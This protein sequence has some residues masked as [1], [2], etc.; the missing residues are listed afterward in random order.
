MVPFHDH[1]L[2]VNATHL[3][4]VFAPSAHRVQVIPTPIG[5]V[6]RPEVAPLSFLP[7]E[8]WE[9]SVDLWKAN[10]P[11]TTRRV[12]AGSWYRDH[13]VKGTKRAIARRQ[14]AR[15]AAPGRG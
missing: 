6:K 1:L 14:A 15:R 9:N 8:A 7:F 3:E 11:A 12:V 10:W 2:P 5:T 4:Q 13:G